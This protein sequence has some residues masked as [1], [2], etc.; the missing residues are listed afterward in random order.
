MC[1]CVKGCERRSVDPERVRFYGRSRVIER[2]CVLCGLALQAALVAERA[3]PA[4][5]E[6]TVVAD[7]LHI[8]ACVASLDAVHADGVPLCCV[9]G[10]TSAQPH[11]TVSNL[12]GTN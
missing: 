2:V 12:Q 1:K 6:E 4:V 10:L 11:Q 5:A 8:V 9:A 7:E 3:G